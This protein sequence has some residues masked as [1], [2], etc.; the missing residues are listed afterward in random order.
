[1]NIVQAEENLKKITTKFSKDTFVFDLLIAYD[2]PKATISKLRIKN[3]NFDDVVVPTKL[4]FVGVAKKELDSKFDELVKDY[5]TAKKAPRFIIVTDY[6]TLKAYDTRVAEKLDTEIKNLSKHPDF[7]LPWV[8]IEK[9]IFQG[10]NPADV[11]A[12]EKLAKFFDLILK[13]NLKLVEKERH[14]LN[15]FL[16]RIL[17]CFFAEDTDIFKKGLFTESLAS[18]TKADGS[19]L[20]EYLQRL[21]DLLN[22]KL[23]TGLPGYLKEFPYVNGGLFAEEFPI[24]KFSKKSRE[25]LIDLGSD[26]NWAEINPDI[27]GSMIQ[28]VVHPDQRAGLG[29][30]YTSVSNIMKVIEPLFLTE[31]KEE[32]ASAKGNK[33]KLKKILKRIGNIKIFDPAC[34]S[35]NFLII[36]YKELRLLEM[37]ILKALGEI[38]MSGITLS[39]FYGIEIDDFA[40]EVAKLSLWLAEHQMD[41]LFNKQF[42]DVKASLP[43]KESGKIVCGNATRLDW[44]KVCPNKHEFEVYV[45]GNPPYLGSRYQEE[46]HKSDM[47]FV[48]GKTDGN[49]KVL[50]YIGCW[51]QIGSAYIQGSNNSKLAFVSTNSISQGE[52]V[53]TLWPKILQNDLEIGFA[54]TSFKWTNNAKK[55]A[56]V[57]CVIIGLRNHSSEAKYL[58]KNSTLKKVKNINAYLM[59]APNIFV[60]RR[61]RPLATLLPKMES[62]NKAVDG[63]HLFLTQEEVKQLKNE[64]LNYVIKR[65]VGAEEFLNGKDRWCLWITDKNLSKVSGNA[66]V[67]KKIL[68]CKESRLESKDNGA[69]ELADRPHQFREMNEC[70]GH[71][72]I[73]PTVSSERREYIPVGVLSKDDIVIAPNQI[74]YDADMWVF[75]I[76]SSK[77]HIL[78]LRTVSGRLKSDYRYS[79]ALCYNTF[80][81]KPLTDKQKD[82]L[83]ICAMNIIAERVKHP[84]KTLAQI[85]D[86]DSMPDQ[87]KRRHEELD[88][89]LE[90]ICNGKM[91]LNDE[92]RLDFLFNLYTN[93]NEA[94]Q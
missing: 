53:S 71:S 3:K 86:P 46:S 35:G 85:Y 18:H 40:H 4:H 66:L 49:Y 10:E 6:Q 13:D 54:H 47:D 34:G 94:D 21:F 45:L 61:S 51:F 2:F 27:F 56:A 89:C 87:L 74:I 81:L 73:V 20:D 36:A 50:D 65:A 39:N 83:N 8:G 55:K 82:S 48:F 30:H 12:A 37:D 60:E 9:K 59:D 38:P 28:A 69:R 15:V 11:K 78:W 70:R 90:I 88:R 24:P 33:N 84:D 72:F 92:D 93:M 76:L 75:A 31:L 52:Q 57:I 17:F 63:G 43:L 67:K 22:K 58:Y 19:D 64:K 25:S 14:A 44:Q 16:T 68:R 1:M 41:V 62:G 42:G 32:F 80:P 79:S 5:S 29:M 26:L 91:F 23:R 77:L 7:F